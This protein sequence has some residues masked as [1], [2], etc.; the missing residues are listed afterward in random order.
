[1]VIV[2]FSDYACPYCA[3]F[4]LEV[5]PE[6]IKNYGDKVKI[7][8]RDFPVHGETSYFAAEAANCAGEQGKYW[9]FHDVLF[10]R[11]NEWIGNRTKVYDYAAELGLNV[12]DFKACLDSG[13]YEDEITKDMSDGQSYGVTGTPTFF[14]NGKKVVGYKSYEEFAALIEQELQQ[15]S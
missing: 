8:F 2:E 9:D 4:A 5:E 1:M 14:I 15:A 13:K 12:D 3:K 10:E 11:Q 7:V 6:I